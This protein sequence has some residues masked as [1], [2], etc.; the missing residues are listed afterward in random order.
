[1]KRPIKIKLEVVKIPPGLH[2]S[3]SIGQRG[4]SIYVAKLSEAL[5]SG[6]AIQ[7]KAD[8]GY[9]KT[10]L[11]MAAGKLKVK[12]VYALDGDSLYIKPLAIEGELKRLMV[13]LRE[14]RSVPE[15][16]AKKFELHLS[17]TLADLASQT[18]AHL[19]KDKWVLTEKGM[20]A[21]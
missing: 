13:L 19:H 1:M 15:L 14:P 11:R 20:D 8:D 17:N 7:V 21:L 9:M 12:L 18:L 16:Q 6:G 5:N 2:F 10:Q 3:D 4:V